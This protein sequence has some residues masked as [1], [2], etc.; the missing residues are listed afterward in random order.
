[1][2]TYDQNAGQ[3]GDSDYFRFTS[4]YYRRA[5]DE[6]GFDVKVLEARGGALAMIGEALSSFV[7]Y[8]ACSIL[9]RRILA[10]V[11]RIIESP[12]AVLDPF[13]CDSN[14]PIGHVVVGRKRCSK[15]ET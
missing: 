5:F 4:A 15:A 2:L 14:N 13:L 12:F 1:M 11:C 9:S 8:S 10:C 3:A 7:Y 6:A